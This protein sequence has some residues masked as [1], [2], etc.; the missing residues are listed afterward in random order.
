MDLDYR[1]DGPDNAPV[2]VL[3]NSLGTRWSLWDT[4]VETWSKTFRILRY[5]TRGHGGSPI[6]HC[7]LTLEK[8]G[9]DV[10]ALLDHLHIARAYFCGISLGG[11]TG[12]WLNRYAADRFERMVV[13]NTA[14]K[15]GH[16]EAWMSRAA[17]VRRE[18]LS[19]LAD[20]AGSRWFS[21]A[22][23]REQPAIV[24]HFKQDLR[25]LSAQGYASCCEALANADLR[26][27]I[28]ALSCPLL[29]IAGDYDPVTTV[30]DAITLVQQVKNSELLRLP[31]SHL[32][33]VECSTTFAQSV[34]QF[35]TR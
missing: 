5:N 4:Q 22:F 10:V 7:Q 31:A 29:V 18:G 16:Y 14:A 27:E 8:L 12:L 1:L 19:A 13:A 9:Q 30:N 11:L 24:E 33:N 2:L 26:D 15:I 28:N 32:S 20:S 21:E 35:L 3:S 23:L 34:T 25:H 6:G 17:Q